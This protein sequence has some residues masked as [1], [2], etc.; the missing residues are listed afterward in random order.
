MADITREQIRAAIDSVTGDPS[1]G[2][3]HDLTP[4]IVDAIMDVVAP[5]PAKSKRVIEA[6]ETR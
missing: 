3:V 1:V 2:V 5:A 6:S 4:A